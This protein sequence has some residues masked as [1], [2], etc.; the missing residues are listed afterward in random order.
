MQYDIITIFPKILDAYFNESILKRAQQARLI[1]IKTH[2]LRD[3]TA[4]KHRSVDDAPYGGG[5]GMVLMVEPIYKCLKK[6]KR[7]K[8]SRVILL[9]PA[10]KQFDQKM[11]EKFSKLDQLVFIC[12]RY[13]GIDARVDNLIDEKISVGPYV[14][15][16]GELPAAIIIEATARLLPGVLG[17]IESTEYETFAGEKSDVV[18][19]P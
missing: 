19:Y 15:S 3:Y 1:N 4:D 14:L 6:I 17:K 10:G 5:P 8:K 7:Q 2:D 12:G 13:E 11:A 9:D 18:E 16:G